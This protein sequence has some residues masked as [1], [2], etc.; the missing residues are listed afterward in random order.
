MKF[1]SIILILLVFIAC[2]SEQKK[3]TKAINQKIL[4]GDFDMYEKLDICRCDSL[5]IDSLNTYY[6]HDSLYTGVCFYTYPN[7]NKKSEIKQIFKGQL[8]GNRI[9]LSEEGDTLVKSIY[10]LGELVNQI[11]SEPIV[12]HCDS[13]NKISNENDETLMLYK[14]LPFNG[15]CQ[16][17]FPVPDTNKI[18]LEIPYKNGFIHGD[19]IFYNRQGNEILAEPYENGEKVK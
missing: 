15:V 11:T 17:F 13:L 19:M 18:Y 7:S 2:Q 8:H 5:Q 9:A 10:N 14:D 3:D 6:K 12:C 1:V 16:R 4:A